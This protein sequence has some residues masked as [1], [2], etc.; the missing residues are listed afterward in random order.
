MLVAER[1][2]TGGFP[3][4]TLDSGVISCIKEG[5]LPPPPFLF[6]GCRAKLIDEAMALAVLFIVGVTLSL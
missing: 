6:R 5:T 1:P 4:M 2:E 3:L